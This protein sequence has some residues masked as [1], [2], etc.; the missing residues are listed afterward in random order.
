MNRNLDFWIPL[1][2][3]FSLFNIPFLPLIDTI[4]STGSH[5]DYLKLIPFI[6][7]DVILA[8]MLISLLLGK[9]GEICIYMLLFVFTTI[10]YPWVYSM[11]YLSLDMDFSLHFVVYVLLSSILWILCLCLIQKMMVGSYLSKKQHSFLR[12]VFMVSW[13]VV[14]YCGFLTPGLIYMIGVEHIIYSPYIVVFFVFAVFSVILGLLFGKYFP[15]GLNDRPKNRR[16]FRYV[17][18]VH[19]ILFTPG[20]MSLA[21]EIAYFKA[22]NANIF[23]PLMLAALIPMSNFLITFYVLIHLILLCASSKFSYFSQKASSQQ[24]EPLTSENDL[25]KANNNCN[26]CSK[27]LDKGETSFIT[28]FQNCGHSFHSE[29]ANKSKDVMTEDHCP[30]CGVVGLKFEK[31]MDGSLWPDLIVKYLD[32]FG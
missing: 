31:S 22:E 28:T 16:N 1:L 15:R 19:L 5:E 7:V 8:L 26:S 17:C 32:R 21:S 24:G 9:R 4:V 18:F 3:L 25:E 11:L 29:C 20:F 13:R 30:M 14:V 6:S 2:V 12:T 27:P 23:I 10:G